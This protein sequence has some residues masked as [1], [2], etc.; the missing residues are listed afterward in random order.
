MPAGRPSKYDPAFCDTVIEAGA[1]GDTLTAMAEACGVHRETLNDWMEIHPEFSASVKMGLQKAQA[2]WE[3]KGKVATFGEQPGFN[4]TSFIF[5]MKNRFK[6]DWAD[7]T[8]AELTGKDG[9]AIETKETGQGAAV[10]S[11]FIDAL[12]ERSGAAGEPAE[13]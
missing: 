8:K 10:L 9:G 3:Q 7:V 4:A 12:A 6:D 1:N 11:A 13:E 2:W 5:N